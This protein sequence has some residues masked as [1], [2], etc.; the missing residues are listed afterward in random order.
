LFFP[1]FCFSFKEEDVEDGKKHKKRRVIT[2]IVRKEK[3]I[4]NIEAND[5]DFFKVKIGLTD[6]YEEVLKKVWEK[7][8]KQ[9][10]AFFASKFFVCFSFAFLFFFCRFV[11]LTASLLSFFLFFFFFLVC[12]FSFLVPLPWSPLII[13]QF[14]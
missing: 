8:K 6:A 12:V 13:I 4:S 2:V 7:G 10:F 3:R 14:T 5:R 1:F 11:D 9:Y